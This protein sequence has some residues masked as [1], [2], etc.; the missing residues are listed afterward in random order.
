M[1]ERVG[2]PDESSPRPA[3][4]DDEAMRQ[5]LGLVEE[6]LREL[7]GLG[8]PADEELLWGRPTGAPA[9]QPSST[10]AQQQGQQQQAWV[11]QQQQQGQGQQQQ[12]Q[13][14]SGRSTSPFSSPAVQQ[15]QQWRSGSQ[16]LDAAG[17]PQNSLLLTGAGEGESLNG[18]QNTSME[19]KTTLFGGISRRPLSHSVTPTANQILDQKLC[20]RTRRSHPSSLT[21][22]GALVAC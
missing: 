8:S 6:E 14:L 21:L 12:G 20:C 13:A 11:P 7:I 15:Q 3:D 16:S 19:G 18:R 22:S 1:I 17:S 5:Q 4:N 9:S 2:M 10:M